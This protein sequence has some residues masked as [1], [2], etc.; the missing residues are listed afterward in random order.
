MYYKYGER[1][2]ATYHVKCNLPV[3]TNAK[4]C[5]EVQKKSVAQLQDEGDLA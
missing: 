2:A 1:W 5:V 4:S 3:V